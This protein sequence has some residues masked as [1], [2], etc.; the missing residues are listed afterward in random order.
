MIYVKRYCYYIF[1]SHVHI[2]IC[3]N[4]NLCDETETMATDLIERMG[5]RERARGFINEI[6]SNVYKYKCS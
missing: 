1:V 2:N 5:E 4:F 6:V 3:T